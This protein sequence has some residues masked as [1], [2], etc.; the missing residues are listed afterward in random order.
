MEELSPEAQ[1]IYD[2]LKVSAKEVVEERVDA[3][4]SSATKAMTQLI[5]DNDSRFSEL[6]SKVDNAMIE[7]QQALDKIGNGGSKSAT[8]IATRAASAHASMEEAEGQI[9]NRGET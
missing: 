6:H 5:K 4:R 7:I 3:Y 2:L 1:Q 9:G 8:P